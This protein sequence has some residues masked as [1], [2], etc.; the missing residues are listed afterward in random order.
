MTNDGCAQWLWS[1]SDDS[2]D[3]HSDG[4][5]NYGR[6]FAMIVTMTMMA[7]MMV[8]MTSLLLMMVATMI[9]MTFVIVVKV[10]MTVRGLLTYEDGD[11]S[12]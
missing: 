1:D 12:Q 10:A 8:A 2:D 4:G 9:V 11:D 7:G 3:E 6:G 5:D